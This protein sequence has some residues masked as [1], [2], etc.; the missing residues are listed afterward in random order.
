MYE[1]FLQILS[2]QFVCLVLKPI[3]FITMRWKYYIVEWR[4]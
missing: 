2:M 3:G 4:S 1:S